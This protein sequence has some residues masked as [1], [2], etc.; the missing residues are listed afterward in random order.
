MLCFEV[1]VNLLNEIFGREQ[2]WK[3]DGVKERSGYDQRCPEQSR[4][5]WEIKV[6]LSQNP[7]QLEHA[8]TCLV[9]HDARFLFE[10][11]LL[12][13]KGSCSIL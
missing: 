12:S 10:N 1:S 7:V 4:L 2:V 11:L 6:G 9:K 3:V 8:M 13:F 5:D